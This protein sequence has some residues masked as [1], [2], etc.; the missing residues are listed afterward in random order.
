MENIVE[1]KDLQ[2]NKK[3]LI[4][5][6]NDH[7]SAFSDKIEAQQ[8]RH[9]MLQIFLS[10]GIPLDLNVNGKTVSAAWVLVDTNS[11]HRF[12]TKNIMHFTMLIENTSSLA[13]SLQ[14]QYLNSEQGFAILD[15]YNPE[16]A[17]KACCDFLS[18]RSSQAYN[19]LI[20]TLCGLLNVET[21]KTEYDKRINKLL[22]K[23][24]N[25]D[26]SQHSVEAIASEI[27]L[28]SSRLAHLFKDET[29]MPLKS[30]IVLHKLQKAYEILLE[31]K[32]SI[33][34]AAMMAGFDSPS[35]LA[36]TNRSLMGLSAR[37]LLKDSE[38]LKV[39]SFLR[40]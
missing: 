15:G 35:H 38:F 13:A 29:G 4:I 40:V 27:Y 18:I 34:D 10:F 16:A 21:K 9:W 8:H 14:R 30:Y 5:M 33:T 22:Q 19:D 1:L 6:S 23:L 31:G 25:C 2:G 37:K 24:D 20:N 28:S 39:K 12:S 17:Q 11:Q 32:T 26:C 3:P 7:F 36:A